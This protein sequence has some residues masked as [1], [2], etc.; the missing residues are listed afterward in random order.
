MLNLLSHTIYLL[1]DKSLQLDRSDDYI[2]KDMLNVPDAKIIGNLEN[3]ETRLFSN[4]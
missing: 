4:F 3:P 2:L 1:F